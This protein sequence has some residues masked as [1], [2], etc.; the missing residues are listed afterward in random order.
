MTEFILKVVYK[1]E[2]FEHEA[3]TQNESYMVTVS[4]FTWCALHRH[5]LKV[6]YTIEVN[7][8]LVRVAQDLSQTLFQFIS[9]VNN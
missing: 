3:V 2:V 6:F 9:T 8:I 5:V 1:H 7:N 4:E